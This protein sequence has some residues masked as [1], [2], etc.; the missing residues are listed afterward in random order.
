MRSTFSFI[1][2]YNK[3]PGNNCPNQIEKW[4]KTTKI[5]GLQTIK[6]YGRVVRKERK[7]PM[8]SLGDQ[9]AAGGSRN[10]F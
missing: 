1:A 2:A 10:C 6:K 8:G 3:N 4:S 5:V 9:A 7:F